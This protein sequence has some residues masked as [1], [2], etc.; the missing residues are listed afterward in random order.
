MLTAPSFRFAAQAVADLTEALR[1][2]PTSPDAFSERGEALIVRDFII[3]CFFGRASAVALPEPL[4]GESGQPSSRSMVAMVATIIAQ[5]RG[6]GRLFAT[7]RVEAELLNCGSMSWMPDKL[8]GPCPLAVTLHVTTKRT[9]GAFIHGLLC[10]S[11]G[12]Y[13]A[14]GR[15][16][17]LVLLPSK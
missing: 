14:K 8:P 6:K 15:D 11:A 1:L 2:D 5:I 16:A 13:V 10:A 4:V 12:D 7:V 3:S 17:S 9:S